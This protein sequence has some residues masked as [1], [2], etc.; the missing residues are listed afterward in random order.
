MA[1]APGLGN[2]GR[3]R[4]RFN[5]GTKQVG[6]HHV[7]KYEEQ[8]YG[9]PRSV[10]TQPT[11]DWEYPDS[12]RVMAYQYDFDTQQLR[13]R[14]IKY[15]TPWVYDNVPTTV[16]QAFDAAPSKGRYINSTLN[17]FTYRRATPGEEAKYFVGV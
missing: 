14:F 6:G 1:A 12:S 8:M 5:L 9:T 15:R 11:T 13:V 10:P 16:F 2:W 3:E 4:A 17:Y 7:T